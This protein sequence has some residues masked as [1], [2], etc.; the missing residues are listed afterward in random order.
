MPKFEVDISYNVPEWD[1]I[2]IES[3]QDADEAEVDA[4]TEFRSLFPEAADPEVTA[5]R[6]LD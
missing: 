3:A 2:T 5:V 1:T 4:L 6:A